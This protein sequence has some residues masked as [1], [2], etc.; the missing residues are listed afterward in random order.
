M[1]KNLAPLSFLVLMSGFINAAMLRAEEKPTP[2]PATVNLLDAARTG[3]TG[4]V[5]AHVHWKSEL[6]VQDQ[7]GN[8]AL[9]I[10]CGKAFQQIV[11]LLLDGGANL[12]AKNAN[13][14]TPLGV[15]IANN[16]TDIVDF[17]IQRN[18]AID[19]PNNASE[20]P[21]HMAARNGN[22][23]VVKLIIAKKAEMNAK[24]SDG[25]TALDTAILRGDAETKTL[26]TVAGASQSA[27]AKTDKTL[28]DAINAGDNE[29]MNVLL[30]HGINVNSKD[31]DSS[32]PL[33][34]AISNHNK[35]MAI[36][37]IK[38]GAKL[39][40]E[41]A[42]EGAIIMGDTEQ[43]AIIFDLGININA[44]NTDGYAPLH[45]AITFKN[46]FKSIL[47]A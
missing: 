42:L 44:K 30:R 18:A 38:S 27:S 11:T 4:Q 20:T 39:A 21:L 19:I 23:K 28:Y 34:C 15:A 25:W 29:R 12:N 17:L 37:L 16:Q 22:A 1:R 40:I 32:T 2:P 6:N 14:F 13:G 8:T 7:D 26:L 5:A 24:D 46:W 35:K 10:A 45:R 9:H 41:K 33:D 43:L 31:E 47:V 36:Q 3:N